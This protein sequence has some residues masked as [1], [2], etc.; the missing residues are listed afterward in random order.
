MSKWNHSICEDCWKK[1]NPD[2]E[3]SRLVDAVTEVCCYCMNFHK[4]GILVR[5]NPD[6]LLCKGDHTGV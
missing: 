4:S 3:P 5:D 1:K 2:R 6:N